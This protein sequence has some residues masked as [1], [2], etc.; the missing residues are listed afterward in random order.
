MLRNGQEIGRKKEE[1]LKIFGE[2]G[3]RGKKENMD[4]QN[5]SSIGA[6]LGGI[7]RRAV[8]KQRLIFSG[9]VHH[10]LAFARYFPS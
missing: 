5:L 6:L 1:M 4:K 7:C 10:S 8:L 9:H 3:K 2:I